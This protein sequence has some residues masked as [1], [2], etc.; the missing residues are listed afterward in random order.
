MRAQIAALELKAQESATAAEKKGS[1]LE[2]LREHLIEMENTHTADAL[3]REEVCVCACVCVC[4]CMCGC[5]CVCAHARVCVCVCV[6][7]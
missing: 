2:R 1:Q 7:E 4:V 6:C 3:Q 5:V